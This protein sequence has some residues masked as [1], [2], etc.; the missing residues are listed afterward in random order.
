MTAIRRSNS[1]RS[2]AKSSFTN[3]STAASSAT[4]SSLPTFNARPVVPQ[5]GFALTFA[6]AIRSLRPSNSPVSFGPRIAFPPLSAI[7]SKPIFA[8][9]AT[10]STGGTSAAASMSVGTLCLWASSAHSSRFSFPASCAM[11]IKNINAVRSL[12]AFATSAAV[13]TSISLAPTPKSWL[14]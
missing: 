11:F 9:S 5:F 10:R 14:S 3:R 2:T 1:F 8:Y 7:R 13:S 12:T 6:A 4:I